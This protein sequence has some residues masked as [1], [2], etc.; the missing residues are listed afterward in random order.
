ME[1]S[2]YLAGRPWRLWG[3]LLTPPAGCGLVLNGSQI[4]SACRL[5]GIRLY[6]LVISNAAIP[7]VASWTLFSPPVSP[8]WVNL[9]P[10]NRAIYISFSATPALSK[11]GLD[12]LELPSQGEATGRFSADLLGSSIGRLLKKFRSESKYFHAAF[13]ARDRYVRDAT[14]R[15]SPI[16]FAYRFHVVR[17]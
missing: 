9:Q 1:G 13:S 17:K 14:Y 4:R 7:A 12:S 15:R 6:W 5:V 10:F 3:I 16:R 11:K 2:V 8:C